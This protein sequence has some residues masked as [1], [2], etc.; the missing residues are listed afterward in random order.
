MRQNIPE[1][2]ASLGGDEVYAIGMCPVIDLEL[3]TQRSISKNNSLRFRVIMLA[4]KTRDRH[5]HLEPLDQLDR[6]GVT[7]L[8]IEHSDG[9]VCIELSK[10]RNSHIRSWFAYVFFA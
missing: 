7:G 1:K 6:Y 5:Q 2:A 9:H 8:A 10:P 3:D 4:Q